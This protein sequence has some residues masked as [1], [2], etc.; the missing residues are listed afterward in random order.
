MQIER[1]KTIFKIFST[2][3]K[4]I[5]LL[6]YNRKGKTMT[7]NYSMLNIGYRMGNLARDIELVIEKKNGSTEIILEN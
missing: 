2:R 3:T 1:E 6:T 4:N 7:S 5:S